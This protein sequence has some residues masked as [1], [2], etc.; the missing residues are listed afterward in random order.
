MASKSF[1]R[2]PPSS[3]PE[4]LQLFGS[5]DATFERNSAGA[6]FQLVRLTQGLADNS[7]LLGV[8]RSPGEQWPARAL[9]VAQ[10]RW[11]ASGIV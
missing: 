5:L 8:A 9:C 6:A 3:V 11:E 4:L 7:S 10:D 1:S 2:A